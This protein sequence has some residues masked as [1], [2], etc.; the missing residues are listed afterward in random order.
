M[1]ALVRNAGGFA[2]NYFKMRLILPK[3]NAYANVEPK[4]LLLLW[5]NNRLFLRYNFLNNFSNTHLMDLYRCVT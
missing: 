3:S 5:L 4:V 1:P 2:V